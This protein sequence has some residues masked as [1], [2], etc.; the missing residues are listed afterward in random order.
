V[1]GDAAPSIGIVVINRNGMPH[2][3]VALAAVVAQADELR[4][5]IGADVDVVFV[6]G[7]STDENLDEIGRWPSVRLVPQRG[8]GIADARNFGVASVVGEL[9]AFCDSDD[10]WTDGSLLARVEHLRSNVD[11]S[12]VIGLIVTHQLDGADVPDHRVERLGEAVVGYTPGAMVARRT[13]LD[14]VGPFDESLS[15]GTD[16]DW[17]I[18]AVGAGL[19]PDVVPEVVLRKGVRA[20]SASTAIATYRREMLSVARAHVHRRRG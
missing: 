6:D 17:F 5:S 16:S 18:R 15:I 11:V 10:V 1:P 8:S 3:A 20:D 13:T 14:M 2:L 4:E 9:I 12:S 7:Q 19:A